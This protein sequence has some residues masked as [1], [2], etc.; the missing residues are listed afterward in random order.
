MFSNLSS[1]ISKLVSSFPTMDTNEFMFNPNIPNP[2]LHVLN[3]CVEKM[4]K[5]IKHVEIERTLPL[6]TLPI[7][8]DN[9][10]NKMRETFPACVIGS[11][12][13]G[14]L[15]EANELSKVE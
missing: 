12:S 10:A 14:D 3:I 7:D 6:H 1:N 15:G 4:L 5:P 8:H 2:D 9:G 11:G 13:I